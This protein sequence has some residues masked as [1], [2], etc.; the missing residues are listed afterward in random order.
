MATAEQI[1]KAK[2]MGWSDR[3]S[4]RGD[5][6]DFIDADE[7][8]S[9]GEKLM[10]ILKANNR[11]L[12]GEVRELKTIV[13]QQGQ[14]LQ[15]ATSAL[16]EFR[17]Q[18]AQSRVDRL[19]A[20]KQRTLAEKTAAIQADDAA[21]QT[22]ADDRLA[23]LNGEIAEAEKAVGTANPTG[24][25]GNPPRSNTQ[26]DPAYQSWLAANSWYGTDARKTRYANG[27]AQELR[28]TPGNENLVGEA[29]Y[30]KVTEEVA[31]EF[32][33]RRS[34]TSKTEPG[35]NGSGDGG[36]GSGGGNG[37]DRSYS[38]LPADAKTVCDRQANNARMVGEGKA[39]KTKDAYR[40]HYA[41]QYFKE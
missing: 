24:R 6:S 4:F 14:Q 21:G 39:F 37:S 34:Q 28:G 25:T 7:F 30:Q 20:E 38:D 41:D 16:E 10:P 19:K 23:Q 2:E 9:R 12:A 15:Q 17:K 11:K 26:P 36:G 18:G 35:G 8:V 22:Q 31:R 33:V 1:A 27:V 32:P 29:F 40:Q 3:E 5:Q 13:T